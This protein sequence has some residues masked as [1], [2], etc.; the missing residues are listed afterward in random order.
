[1]G[2]KKKGGSEKWNICRRMFNMGVTS[3][4]DLS[5]TQT[6]KLHPKG[7]EASDA[8]G[9]RK[10]VTVVNRINIMFSVEYLI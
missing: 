6:G 9:R 8:E 2:R 7:Q 1:M 5:V 10:L 4:I 3:Q